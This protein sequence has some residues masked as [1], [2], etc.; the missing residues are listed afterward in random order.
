MHQRAA[1]NYCFPGNRAGGRDNYKDHG[2]ESLHQFSLHN[3]GVA[4]P[5]PRAAHR[6]LDEKRSSHQI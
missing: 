1:C 4:S 2:A 6:D 5:H 3:M